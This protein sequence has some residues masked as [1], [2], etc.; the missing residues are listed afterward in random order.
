RRRRAPKETRAWATSP[1]DPPPPLPASE[2]RAARS[3]S[4][5]T[6]P[7]PPE[8]APP[9]V[10][11]AP[12]A[13]EPW[14]PPFDPLAFPNPSALGRNLSELAARGQVDPLI[15]RERE[16]EAAVDILGKRRGNNPV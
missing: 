11:D 15:G 5:F 7:P 8:P 6:P 10:E 4:R 12:R 9:P 14:A 16:V 13:D 2:E 3:Y 1:P